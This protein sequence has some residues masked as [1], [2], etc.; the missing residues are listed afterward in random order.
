MVEQDLL[1]KALPPRCVYVG[2]KT[3][4]VYWGSPLKTMLPTSTSSVKFRQYGALILIIPAG[5]YRQMTWETQLPPQ[6]EAMAQPNEMD[7]FQI[8][9]EKW[10]VSGSPAGGLAGGLF[11]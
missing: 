5:S 2:G 1:G 8:I 10:P 4:L 3:F 11:T 9:C 6:L 7:E